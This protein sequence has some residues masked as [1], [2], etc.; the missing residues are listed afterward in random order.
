MMRV[1]AQQQQ[2]RNWTKPRQHIN[3]KG[4]LRLV[5][6]VMLSGTDEWMNSLKWN[7]NLMLDDFL[8]GTN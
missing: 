6:V 5:A 2:Q 1:I 3:M 7:L 8:G 4:L